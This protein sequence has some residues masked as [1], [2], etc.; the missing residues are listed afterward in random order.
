MDRDDNRPCRRAQLRGFFW[1]C[2]FR[3]S[4]CR[5]GYLAARIQPGRELKAESFLCLQ[6]W[7]NGSIHFLLGGRIGAQGQNGEINPPLQEKFV[8]ACGR[9][10]A[11][12]RRLRTELT[13]E[14]QL[15]SSCARTSRR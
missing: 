13:R 12:W 10:S 8:R 5:A 7:T 1:W 15:N 14:Q 2:G 6:R 9:R 4:A 3:F 11:R